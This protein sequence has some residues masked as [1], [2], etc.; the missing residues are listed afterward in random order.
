MLGIVS[1]EGISAVL[2]GGH[3]LRVEGVLLVLWQWLW[4][5]F[6]GLSGEDKNET[7]FGSNSLET[8]EQAIAL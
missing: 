7:Y 4:A 1:C 8:S 6:L 5:Q 3:D 2:V